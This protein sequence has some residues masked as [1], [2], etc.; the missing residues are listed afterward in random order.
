MCYVS[1]VISDR[2]GNGLAI[3]NDYETEGV[4]GDLG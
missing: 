4:C 3:S 1:I 2:S